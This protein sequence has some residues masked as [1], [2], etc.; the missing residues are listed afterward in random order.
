MDLKQTASQLSEIEQKTIKTLS[1][2][3]QSLQEI[4]KKTG[5]ASDSVHRALQWLAQKKLID[6]NTAKKTFFE[7]TALGKKPMP[8]RKL[9]SVVTKEIYLNEL[10]KEAGLDEKEFNIALGKLKQQNFIMINA[11]KVSLT[12]V[13]EEFSKEKFLQETIL[14]KIE[15]KQEI[16]QEDQKNALQELLKRGLVK[17]SEKSSFSAKLN[18][19]GIQVQR[20]IGHGIKRTY[21]IF[22][23]TPTIFIGKKQ[24][25]VQFLNHIRKTLVKIGFKEMKERLVVQEFYNFDVLFQPQNH[26]ARTWTDTYQLKNPT[27]GE[28]PD[29]KKVQAVAAAHENGG[30]SGSRGWGYKW[31]PKI[32][33]R[34]MPN[35]HGTSADARQMIEGA[36]E[37]KYFVINRC[38]RPDVLDATHLVEFNQLDGFIVSKDLSFAH[39]LGILT[40]FATEIAG[41]KEVR[42]YPDYYP[43][44]EPSVQLSAKHPQLGWIEFAGAGIFRPEITQNLGIK[45]P[46]LAWGM[47]VD[48]LAMFKLGIKDIRH[49]F[50]EDLGWLRK[51]KAVME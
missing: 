26:P 43:F 19:N 3:E 18:E 46:V 20:I 15:N 7:I 31:D 16:M 50:S 6:L 28:L 23:P 8:E 42:F 5:L 48:R 40:E 17:Q 22:D 47:G 14:E 38:Y 4:E 10:K 32:A 33:A 35:A 45:E 2:Q 12:V 30:V 11:G 13:G 24:P 37:R 21:N 36:E 29:K 44:T 41:A 1:Q 39:L 49:L 34:L 9:I 51:S 25:Y 27:S